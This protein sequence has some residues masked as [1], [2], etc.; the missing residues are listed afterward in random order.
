MKFLT[1]SPQSPFACVNMQ[2]ASNTS[3]GQ[4]NEQ[5]E[6]NAKLQMNRLS[7]RNNRLKFKNSGQSLII[8]DDLQNIPQISKK[9]Y[10]IATCNRLDFDRLCQQISMALG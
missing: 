8:V 7:L 10:M 2:T 1:Y 9:N 4:S 5:G 3:W 6:L